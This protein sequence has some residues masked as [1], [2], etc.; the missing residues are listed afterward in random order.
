MH[1]PGEGF[2]HKPL[3]H[4]IQS[5]RVI[6]VLPDLTEDGI[7]QSL[8]TQVTTSAEYVCLSYVWG[9]PEPC[10]TIMVDGKPYIVRQ[11]LFD[12][13]EN[14][15]PMDEAIQFW[16]IDAICID[17]GDSDILEGRLCLHLAGQTS[18]DT[19]NQ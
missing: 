5:I 19:I 2:R 1:T 13:L 7:I 6:Q 17:Q 12:F 18:V 8:I 3:D 9:E 11:N 15:R 14:I 16:W 4:S 10:Q